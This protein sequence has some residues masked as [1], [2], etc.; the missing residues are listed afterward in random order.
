MSTLSRLI[1]VA[2][3]ALAFPTFALATDSDTLCK[4]EEAVVFNCFTGKKTASL[5]ASPTEAAPTALA[6]RYGTSQK[7]ENEYI[8]TPTNGKTF[9]ATVSPA[10]PRAWVS[11]VWFDRSSYRYLM[12]ECVGG[13]CPYHAGLTVLNGER[14]AMNASC[15]Q[16]RGVRLPAF[17]RELVKFGSNPGDSQSTTPLLR[18]EEADNGAY[19]L[20]KPAK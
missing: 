11:Q 12:T 18:I 17:S 14:I 1:A 19:E 6:Y 16:P 20:Y 2:G 10:A 3:L 13:D 8:A 9:G 7:I 5:C 15:Q 4:P